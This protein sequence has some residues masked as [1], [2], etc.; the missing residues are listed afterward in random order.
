MMVMLAVFVVV[1]ILMLRTVMLMVMIVVH[2]WHASIPTHFLYTT[3]AVFD[4]VSRS[5]GRPA[6]PTLEF[7]G[8]TG[9]V[10]H[11]QLA[12]R[13]MH[14]Q[15]PPLTHAHTTNHHCIHTCTHASPTTTVYIHAHTYTNSQPIT[16]CPHHHHH[17][18]PIPICVG[19]TLDLASQL[20]R[21]GSI[22]V[23]QY[24]KRL[25]SGHRV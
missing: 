6:I 10:P 17:H 2:V 1:V 9:P 21:T 18:P 22:T 19:Q 13:H 23:A 12:H 14:H 16:T 15:P 11:H 20:E 7:Y 25:R 8:A 3:S 5:C 24:Y 4:A